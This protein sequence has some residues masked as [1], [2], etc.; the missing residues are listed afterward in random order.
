MKKLLLIALAVAV[1]VPAAGAEAAP[2]PPKPTPTLNMALSRTLVTWGDSI[3]ISGQIAGVAIPANGITLTLQESVFPYRGFKNK[4]TV[5]TNA[6]GAYSFVVQPGIYEQYRVRSST[7]P[8]VTTAPQLVK[9][10]HKVTLSVSDDKPR[11]GKKITFFGFSNP[12]TDGV[13]VQIQ[14]RV[15]GGDYVT[16]ANTTLVDAGAAFPL[17]SAFGARVRIFHSGTYRARVSGTLAYAPGAAKRK[18]KIDR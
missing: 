10:R 16:V 11:R 1:V 13:P 14:R 12:P 9:V 17:S 3:T 8:A 6:L 2:K 15:R 7:N 4:A 5:Q 18:I